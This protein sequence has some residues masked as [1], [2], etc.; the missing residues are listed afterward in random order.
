MPGRSRPLVPAAA[1]RR[2]L[3]DGQGLLSDPTRPATPRAVLHAIERLGFVQ[4]DTINRVERAH[5]HILHT[6]LDGYRPLHLKRMLERDRSL[7]EH[8]THD[9]A[10]IR[11]DWLPFWRHRFDAYSQS[12]KLERW[13]RSK[14]GSDHER[15]TRR[16]WRRIT[17]EGALGSRDF[18]DGPAHRGG[19]WWDW[20]PSRAALELMWRTGKLS[21]AG[22][23]GFQKLYDRT[24]RVFPDLRATRKPSANAHLDWACRIALER[25][26]VA[27]P[28]EIA[29]FLE[30]VDTRA[31]GGWLDAARRRGEVVEVDVEGAD[32]SA[33]RPAFALADWAER[34]A[35]AP[36]PP[37]RTRLLNPFDPAIRDRARTR[38]RFGFDYTIECFVPAARRRYGYYVFPILEG[39]R[40]VGRLDPDFD[41]D[42]GVL[43]VRRVFWEGG[44]RATGARWRALE[45]ALD[46]FRG[47]LGAD[48]F[49]IDRS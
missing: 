25:L 34:A 9:A 35:R 12:P 14:L 30:A 2:L 20:K 11:S 13:I 45:G 41:R 23:Q 1:A 32:G 5:E 48:R 33:P 46:R 6:R 19:G 43:R 3:L 24:D 39:D 8:W 22:R 4:V 15:V 47:Q 36:D 31:A 29:H 17:R 18:D 10:V 7:F 16:V 28:G 38:R 26:V 40:F 27:T 44:V 37:D 21:I 42:R 49:E